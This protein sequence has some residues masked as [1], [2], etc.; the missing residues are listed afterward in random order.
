MPALPTA[1]CLPEEKKKINQIAEINSLCMTES[2]FLILNR[3]DRAILLHIL[4]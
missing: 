4:C 1:G 2:M 3:C